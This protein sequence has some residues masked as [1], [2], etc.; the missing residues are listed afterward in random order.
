MKFVP[1]IAPFFFVLLSACSNVQEM[2][3]ESAA[4]AWIADRV[5]DSE[6]LKYRDLKVFNRSAS[7]PDSYAL[8]GELNAKNR[9]G[10]YA[11]WTRF[12]VVGKAD[13]IPRESSSGMI[14]SEQDEE[15][16]QMLWDINCKHSMESH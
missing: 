10:G 13:G 12:Q 9:L 1:T 11:G 8:C 2:R 14:E 7:A 15:V 6:S 5:N 16:F 4:K 3:F